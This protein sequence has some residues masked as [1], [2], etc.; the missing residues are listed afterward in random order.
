[1]KKSSNS[2]PQPPSTL[3]CVLPPA[4][5]TFVQTLKVVFFNFQILSSGR[6]Y[7]EY[8]Q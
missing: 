6:E 5:V 8:C 7:R 3:F 1:M 2:N 4:H